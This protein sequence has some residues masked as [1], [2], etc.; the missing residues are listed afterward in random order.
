MFCLAQVGLSSDQYNGLPLLVVVFDLRHPQ[1]FH[2]LQGVGL[3]H[4]EADD[5][6]LTLGVGEC[7]E[8]FVGLLKQG[9]QETYNY[10][11]G[12]DVI[13]FNDVT[14][15]QVNTAWR[16]AMATS[17]QSRLTSVLLTFNENG[18]L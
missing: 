9:I 3:Y 5:E 11:Y 18:A 6:Y 8:R 17:E 14:S 2:I 4:G 15:L 16:Q 13:C 7:T 12:T 1:S 10:T